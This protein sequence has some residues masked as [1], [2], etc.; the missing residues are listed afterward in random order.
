MSRVEIEYVFNTLL[1]HYI[2][3]HLIAFDDDNN[4][5]NKKVYTHEDGEI[6]GIASCPFDENVI[7]TVYNTSLYFSRPLGWT[8]TK[9]Y[10]YLLMASTHHNWCSGV[11]YNCYIFYLYLYNLIAFEIEEPWIIRY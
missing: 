7:S 2:Q 5:I 3:V 8:S 1:I 9:L 6:W 4:F 11:L 10:I